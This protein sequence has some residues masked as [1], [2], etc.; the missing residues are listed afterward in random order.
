MLIKYAE[1]VLIGGTISV[2]Q[3]PIAAGC[4]LLVGAIGSYINLKLTTALVVSR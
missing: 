4:I 2:K 1:I 3:R